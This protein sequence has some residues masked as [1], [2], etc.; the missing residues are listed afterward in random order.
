MHAER[1]A[2][3]AG[4]RVDLVD[5]DDRRPVLAGAL[6]E[7]SDVLLRL[8]DPLAHHV[9]PGDRIERRAGLRGQHLRDRRLAG[10]GRPREQQPRGRVDAEAARRVG[11]LDDG[12]QLL[13]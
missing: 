3:P 13:H 6:E 7:L 2:T 9:R 12:L 11:V 10:A 1:L 5:E 4:D 8:A